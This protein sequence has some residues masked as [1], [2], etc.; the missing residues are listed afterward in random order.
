M[1]TKVNQL[2][3]GVYL[4]YINLALGSLIPFLYTPIMLRLLGQEEYGLY[5]LANSVVGYLSLLSFGF[6]S[7]IIRYVTKYRIEGNK[8]EVEKLYGFFLKLYGVLGLLVMAGGVIISNNVSTIFKQGLSLHEIDKLKILVLIMAVNIAISFSLSVCSSLIISYERFLYRKIMDIVSTVAVPVVNLIALAQGYASVGMV[9]GSTVTQCVLGFLSIL[10]C[11][12]NLKIKPSFVKINTDII[13]EMI[14]VSFFH[15]LGA[16]VDMLFWATDKVILGMLSSTVAVAVY[17]M[18][19]TFNNIVMS[20]TSSISGVLAPK[21]TGMVVSDIP[22]KEWTALFIKIGRLQFFIIALIISG[23]TVFGQVF[24]DLWVGSEYADSYWIAL[25]TLFP[26]CIPLIQSTGLS[27]VTAQ[28]K[29]YFR[30][31]VYLI[32]AILNA[33]STYMV[34]PYWGGIGAAICSCIS[35]LMGQGII[36]NVYYYRVTGLDIPLFWRN[37]LNMSGI[38]ALMLGIGVLLKSNITIDTWSMFFVGVVGFTSIYLI[39]M[40]IFVMN[41]YEKDIIRKPLKNVSQKLHQK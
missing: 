40:Y 5:S 27:F 12:C 3:A 41:D 17:N 18:G 16:V 21:I 37:I 13:K 15:F 34:T 22:K 26:L 38:P 28:N 30:S 1:S 39:L 20:M 29:H 7:T 25:L 2:R 14:N 24:I 31:V 19:G 10:Y 32:I 33:I 35:Y 36:M 11:T 9:L 23:F 4:S 8:S 6:G